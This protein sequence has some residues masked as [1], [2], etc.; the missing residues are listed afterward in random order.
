MIPIS[1]L[2]PSPS[3]SPAST[4][5]SSPRRIAQQLTL[6]PTSKSTCQPQYSSSQHVLSQSIT[7][8]P[9]PSATPV[10]ARIHAPH[11]SP[12]RRRPR[13]NPHPHRSPPRPTSAAERK[14]QRIINLDVYSIYLRN[15]A[16]LLYRRIQKPDR[17]SP[18]I[19]KTSRL[20]KINLAQYA[21]TRGAPP[22]VWK[23]G[24][25]ALLEIPP[26]SPGYF[27]LTPEELT[28][29]STLRMRPDQYL[30]V[31]ETLLSAAQRGPFKKR[32]A[33]SWFRIDVNKGASQH[34][35]AL[36]I[37]ARSL[38]LL[39]HHP[40]LVEEFVERGAVIK[41][42]D[43]YSEEGSHIGTVSVVLSILMARLGAS[44]VFDPSKKINFAVTGLTVK[45]PHIVGAPQSVTEEILAKY[46]AQHYGIHVEWNTEMDSIAAHDDVV[47]T[48]TKNSTTNSVETIS[49]R[50]VV[51]CDGGHS[52]V[53]HAFNV[54]FKGEALATVFMNVDIHIECPDQPALMHGE[55]G[56]IAI[57]EDPITL[58]LPCDRNTGRV[59]IVA[60]GGGMGPPAKG[61]AIPPPTVEDV[62]KVL[63]HRVPWMKA[64]V[65]DPVW[66]TYF[67]SQE[68]KV[69]EDGYRPHPRVFLAGDAAHVHVPIGGWG[70]NTGFQDVANLAWKLAL[71]LHSP[72]A[73]LSSPL[74]ASYAQERSPVA[75]GL[76]RR[77]TAGAHVLGSNAKA[78]QLMRE[79]L[80]PTALTFSFV[81]SLAAANLSMSV[82]GYPT[83]PLHYVSPKSLTTQLLEM[84]GVGG[85]LVHPGVRAPDGDVVEA[86]PVGEETAPVRIY[87]RIFAPST[88]FVLLLFA[89]NQQEVA[90]HAAGEFT[91]FVSELKRTFAPCVRF[92]P[93]IVAAM[94]AVSLPAIDGLQKWHDLS[95]RVHSDY[96]V[97]LATPTVVLVRPDRYV[98][99]AFTVDETKSVTQFLTTF[100]P[101]GAKL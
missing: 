67:T 43:W 21:D 38:E 22:V 40:G 90:A 88:A 33:K 84:F 95:G 53:R 32:E 36:V 35:R 75:E 46:L 27:L 47:T 30:T 74:L 31:K 98:G 89:G 54:E 101:V 24:A 3:P 26:S 50:F 5:A 55:G 14:S 68:R 62:Q 65:Y 20:P 97:S 18:S 66:M 10:P 49:S 51:A 63:E 13:K 78:F 85:H 11:L 72:N 56:V 64:K 80:V 99:G 100:L 41:K 92:D 71:H 61:V 59:R 37:H 91:V 23:K 25:A 77:T 87:D 16:S 48:T 6:A 69:D 86:G 79:F 2:Y 19:V 15:P 8:R 1:Q 12:A 44:S 76:L 45:F 58:I 93:H 52:P 34:S 42:F 7:A 9:S 83:S 60:A 57:G 73:P 28:T 39:M 17:S 81:R 70:M 82:I 29:C 96:G 94:N 4:R